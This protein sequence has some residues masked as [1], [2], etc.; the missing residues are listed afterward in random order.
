MTSFEVVYKHPWL[1]VEGL[2]RLP[3]HLSPSDG[4]PPSIVMVS[5][6]PCLFLRTEGASSESSSFSLRS[7]W[8]WEC[9]LFFRRLSQ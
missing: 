5:G 2:R 3:I 9:R 7:P 8:N 6:T 1:A 4:I